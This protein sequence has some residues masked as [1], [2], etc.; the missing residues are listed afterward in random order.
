MNNAAGN[1]NQMDVLLQLKNSI[2]Q[3]ISVA[4]VARITS[5][6][7]D[8]SFTRVCTCQSICN[9]S[10]IYKAYAADYVY[11]RI[12]HDDTLSTGQLVVV[13]FTDYNYIKPYLTYTKGNNNTKTNNDVL[14]D[15]L[16]S[17]RYGII[18]DALTF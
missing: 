7:F 9:T 15:N 16:H 18:I 17:T 8:G 6:E 13:L 2:M 11:N 1:K 14:N 5:I 12:R 3:S 10:L 4:D